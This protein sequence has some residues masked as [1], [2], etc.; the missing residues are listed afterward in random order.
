[1]RTCQRFAITLTLITLS[2]TA[3]RAGGSA[4]SQPFDVFTEGLGNAT[5]ASA[6]ER[7]VGLSVGLDGPLH[8][9]GKAAV[10]QPADPRDPDIGS[11]SWTMETQRQIPESRRLGLQ[12][13]GT[14][15]LDPVS[16]TYAQSF[17]GKLTWTFQDAPALTARLRL[18]SDVNIDTAR[19]EA[20]PS[21]G[22]EWETTSRLSGADA[23]VRSELTARVAYRVASEA[24]PDLSARL[25]L[26]F[27][28]RS[29]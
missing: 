9:T 20:V 19:G 26:R 14:G 18:S 16:G 5:T 27:T 25:E 6:A 4:A 2:A 12:I 10:H 15:T 29:R 8:I 24:A 3:A 17:S 1:M 28:P 13:A 21:V 7:V 11:L 23:P 22:P